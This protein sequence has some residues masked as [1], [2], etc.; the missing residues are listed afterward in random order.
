[1]I[2]SRGS[3]DFIR[4]SGLS[5]RQQAGHMTEGR[6]PFTAEIK[7]LAKGASTYDPLENG[8]RRL[9]TDTDMGRHV[10]VERFN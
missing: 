9:R 3:S 5:P 1:L 10:C 7:T 8:I 4:A 2:G 6:Q